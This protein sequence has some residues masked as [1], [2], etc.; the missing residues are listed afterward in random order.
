VQALLQQTLLSP[1]AAVSSKSQRK[2]R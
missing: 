1:P 2:R